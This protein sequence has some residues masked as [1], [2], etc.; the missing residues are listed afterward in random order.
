M[1][2]RMRMLSARRGARVW[3]AYESRT[4]KGGA[5]SQKGGAPRRWGSGS[6]RGRPS[7][8]WD[9]AARLAASADSARVRAAACVRSD[10]PRRELSSVGRRRNKAGSGLARTTRDAATLHDRSASRRRR[11][12]VR[13][14]VRRTLKIVRPDHPSTTTSFAPP[15]R[16]V[17][18]S[19]DKRASLPRRLQIYK[20]PQPPPPPLPHCLCRR[21]TTLSRAPAGA[22]A[23]PASARPEAASGSGLGLGCGCRWEAWRRPEAPWCRPGPAR[24]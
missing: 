19:I 14:K 15:P 24:A 2:T 8:L 18:S 5:S 3:P 12:P 6:E 4:R 21:P 7:P 22:A 20:S 1:R 16:V 10:A 17:F 11:R 23:S 13:R 9:A